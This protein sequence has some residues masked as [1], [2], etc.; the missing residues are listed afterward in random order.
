MNLS[1]ALIALFSGAVSALPQRLRSIQNQHES[2]QQHEDWVH[3]GLASDEDSQRKLKGSPE[4]VQPDMS[5]PLVPLP[6]MSMSMSMPMPALYPPCSVCGAGKVV[7]APNTAFVVPGAEADVTCGKLEQTGLMGSIEPQTCG[8]LVIASQDVCG[9]TEATPVNPIEPVPDN[10][11]EPEPV[12]PVE[13]VPENPS[14]DPIPPPPTTEAPVEPEPEPESEPV[15]LGSTPLFAKS[16]KTSKASTKSAKSKTL[17]DTTMAKVAK[18][19]T[20]AKAE[21]VSK[22]S[23]TKSAKAKSASSG[24]S[25]KAGKL[26]KESMP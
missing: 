20:D 7:G 23:K 14:V 16:V 5:M 21:K 18:S 6:P 25:A 19:A 26:F 10:P 9:C 24:G 11:I 12:N 8:V 4:L 2:L 3:L 17:K 15:P 22:S 1:I 13:P